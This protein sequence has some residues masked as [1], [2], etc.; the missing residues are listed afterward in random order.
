MPMTAQQITAFLSHFNVNI[1]TVVYNGNTTQIKDLPIIGD[2]ADAAAIW[3]NQEAATPYWVWNE[4]LAESAIYDTKSDTGSTWVWGTYKGQSVVEHD[5]WSKLFMG[6]DTNMSHVNNRAGVLEIFGGAGAPTT[7]R[8]HVFAVGR[9]KATNFEKIMATEVL[10]PPS[11]TGND[12]VTGNR[13]KTTNPDELP[14]NLLGTNG[15]FTTI[16]GA[17]IYAA[18][19]GT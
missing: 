17:D 13:G 7:Q 14:D 3:Y 5:T 18:R 8:N 1:N 2:A 16:T 6:G 15:K 9:R 12:G 10:S 11:N 19:G 4:K